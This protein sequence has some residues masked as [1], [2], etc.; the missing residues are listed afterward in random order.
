MTRKLR[1]RLRIIAAR[2][3]LCAAAIAALG[4]TGYRNAPQDADA[5]QAHVAAFPR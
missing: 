5:P 3:T 1:R 2:A 4:F